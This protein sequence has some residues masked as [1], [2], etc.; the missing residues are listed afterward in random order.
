MRN[1]L[2]E[3][4][5]NCTTRDPSISVIVI[6]LEHVLRMASSGSFGR[7]PGSTMGA[8]LV[9]RLTTMASASSSARRGR[10]ETVRH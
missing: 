4:C 1:S 3:K 10:T 5:E 2:T 6:R 8:A 7:Q 9:S